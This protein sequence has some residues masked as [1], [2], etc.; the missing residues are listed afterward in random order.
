MLNNNNY[1]YIRNCE[2]MYEIKSVD[3]T[4]QYKYIRLFI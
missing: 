1:C 3:L 4:L 2:A